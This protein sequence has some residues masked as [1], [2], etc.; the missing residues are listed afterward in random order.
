MAKGKENNNGGNK[1]DWNSP[2]GKAILKNVIAKK[3]AEKTEKAQ[4]PLGRTFQTKDNCFAGQQ[5]AEP[6][7]RRVVE[8]EVNKNNEMGV[9]ALTTKKGKGAHPLPN[10]KSDNGKETYFKCH[11]EITDDKHQPIVKGDKF[12]E[13]H[14]NNDVSPAD[15][16]QIR[17]TIYNPPTP[18]YQRNK[19]RLEILHNRL[20]K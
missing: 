10:Y 5:D 9:V 18:T 2:K 15:V 17:E 12:R 14:K 7:D 16:E 8:I 19:K 11:L 20:K 3:Q 1:I 4:I 6:K 13:N